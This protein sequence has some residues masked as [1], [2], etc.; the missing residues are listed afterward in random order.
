M[1]RIAPI[2]TSDYRFTRRVTAGAS[3]QVDVG[4][5]GTAPVWVRLERSGNTFTAFT[6]DDG[7]AWT[8]L[9][10]PQD[11]IMN[12]TIYVGLAVSARN[13]GS[14]CTVTFDNVSVQ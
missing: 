13:D 8:A 4:P 6:S 12:A 14:L 7:L 3:S 9:G 1:T 5:E 10:A 11:I 2:A